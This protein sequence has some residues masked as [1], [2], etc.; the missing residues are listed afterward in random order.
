M[1]NFSIVLAIAGLLLFIV[2]NFF[3]RNTVNAVDSALE[4]SSFLGVPGAR[5][6]DIGSGVGKFCI[7]AGVYHPETSF[8]GIGQRKELYGY[9]ETAREQ[10]GVHNV[11]FK[12]GNNEILI[13]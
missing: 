5:V 4:A 13:T 11:F 7:A 9:A 1:K 8:Y 12:L 10:I 3:Y 2:P 6:L